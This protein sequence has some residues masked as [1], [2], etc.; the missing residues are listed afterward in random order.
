MIPRIVHLTT[1]TGELTKDEKL[2]LKKNKKIFS[3]WEFKIYSDEDNHRIIEEFFPEFLDKYNNISRG[4]MKA[5]VV[6]CLYLYLYGGLYIDTDYQFFKHIPDEWLNKECVI[7]AEHYESDGTPF[8]GNCIFFS[9][10][11]YGFW[12]DFIKHLFENYDLSS[13]KEHEIISCT[14]PGGVTKFFLENKDK[15]PSLTYTP[16]AV[17][18]PSIINHRLGIKKG[19]ETVGAHYCF[20]G[21]RGKTHSK[22]ARHIYLFIQHLQAR[23]LNVINI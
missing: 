8:L 15:Y 6:R 23:G 11:G 21:W 12:Y 17:F 22:F 16:K 5:D 3:D 13:T 4:V 14:G 19:Q 9:Q 10:K 7:P 20:G 1:K 2:I 18:H